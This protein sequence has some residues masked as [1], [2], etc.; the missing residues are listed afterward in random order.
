MNQER[1]RCCDGRLELQRVNRLQEYQG[2]WILLE[3]LPALVCT[4]CGEQ[5]Y[6]PETHDFVVSLLQ[7]HPQPTRTVTMDIYDV[8][9]LELA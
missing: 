4:Q 7:R 8:D 9:Q 2:S 5:Y 6:T 1:C 3:N